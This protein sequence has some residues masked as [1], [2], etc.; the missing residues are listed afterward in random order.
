MTC[1][2]PDL[3]LEQ[4]EQVTEVGVKMEVVN[5]LAI[6]GGGEGENRGCRKEDPPNSLQKEEVYNND[7]GRRSP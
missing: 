6:E 5:K 3:E 2:D 1:N 4:A 7:L